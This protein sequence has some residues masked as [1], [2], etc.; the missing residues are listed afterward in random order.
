MKSIFK[1]DKWVSVP[2]TPFWIPRIRSW[3]ST[4]TDPQPRPQDAFPR[5]RGWKDSIVNDDEY[6][7]NAFI[8]WM[9]CF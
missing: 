4:K 6:L 2:A 7:S 9:F 5:G 8:E 1:D 3:I